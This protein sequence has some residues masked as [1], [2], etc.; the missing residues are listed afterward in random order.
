MSTVT[1]TP[2]NGTE[3]LVLANGERRVAIDATSAFTAR[4]NVAPVESSD[5]VIRVPVDGSVTIPTNGK[6]TIELTDGK[7][8]VLDV[9]VPLDPH[10]T[11]PERF[12]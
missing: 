8:V 9:R 7:K 5:H 3:L 1:D 6:W 4:I 2:P 11:G 12:L 10:E